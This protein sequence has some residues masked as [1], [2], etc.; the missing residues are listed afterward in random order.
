MN[1]R[2]G[3]TPQA[4]EFMHGSSAPNAGAKAGFM[5]DTLLR[6]HKAARQP[7]QTWFDARLTRRR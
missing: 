2:P 4:T 3:H 5:L 7:L 6:Q 1:T